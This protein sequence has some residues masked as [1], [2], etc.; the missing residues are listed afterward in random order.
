VDAFLNRRLR[1][2]QIHQ[3]NQ[4]TLE[5]YVPSKPANAGDLLDIDAHSRSVAEQAIAGLADT[6]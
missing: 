6:H 4:S 2:D 3:V 1:F 5:R